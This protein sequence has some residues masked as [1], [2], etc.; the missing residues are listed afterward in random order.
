MPN[1]YKYTHFVEIDVT[2]LE[3]VEGRSGVYV[4]PNEGNLDITGRV[5]RSG[6]V[7]K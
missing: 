4:I 6:K 1:K 5:V 3:V 7:G 2:G